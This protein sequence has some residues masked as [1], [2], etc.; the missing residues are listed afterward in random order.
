[1]TKKMLSALI[2]FVIGAC[3]L[4]GSFLFSAVCGSAGCQ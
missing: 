2:I 1:M 4:G 3:C